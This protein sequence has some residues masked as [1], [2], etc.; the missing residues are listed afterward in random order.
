MALN[1]ST[2]PEHKFALS[3]QLKKLDVAF[4]IAKELDDVS[5]WK[6]LSEEALNSW[7]VKLKIK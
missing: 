6:Q 1:V 5:S 2:D 4:E 3:I 7:K